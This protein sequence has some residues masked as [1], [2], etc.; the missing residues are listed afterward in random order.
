[1]A[2][3][4]VPKVLVSFMGWV[5]LLYPLSS[6]PVTPKYRLLNW[7]SVMLT[8]ADDHMIRDIS[9]K[10]PF[11]NTT[12][13]LCAAVADHRKTFIE[14][15]SEFGYLIHKISFTKRFSLSLSLKRFNYSFSPEEYHCQLLFFFSFFFYID[16]KLSDQSVTLSFIYYL[17]FLLLWRHWS[18]SSELATEVA[19]VLKK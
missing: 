5:F 12:A 18:Q 14:I 3:T 19:S 15:I 9:W 4:H 16:S 8:E 11:F 1:M 2:F 6:W 17:A 7:A 13:G 10:R